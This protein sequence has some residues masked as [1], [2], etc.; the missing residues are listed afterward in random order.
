MHAPAR[1]FLISITVALVVIGTVG[2]TAVLDEPLVAVGSAVVIFAVTL[3]MIVGFERLGMIVLTLCFFM[4]PF[5]RAFP[6]VS[7]TAISAV[8]PLLVVAVGLLLP[9]IVRGKLDISPLYVVSGLAF[10][11]IGYA[12]AFSSETALATMNEITEWTFLAMVL[13]LAF[14]ALDLSRAEVSILAVAYIVGQMVSSAWAV[15]DGPN[16]VNNRYEGLAAHPNYFAD[17]AMM[18]ACLLLYLYH[19]PWARTLVMRVMW[20]GAFAVCGGAIYVSGSR[21][22]ALGMAAVLV[23]VPLIE[24]SG[25]YIFL[26]TLGTVTLLLFLQPIADRAGEGSTLARLTGQD[27]TGTRTTDFRLDEWHEAIDKIR[28]SPFLGNGLTLDILSFHNNYLSIA[29]GI[30]IFGVAAYLTTLWAMGRGLLSTS[31]QRRLLY[32]VVAFAVWGLTQPGF[33]DRSN[34]LPL[35]LGIAV[36]HC[37][38]TARASW[39]QEADEDADAAARAGIEESTTPLAPVADRSTP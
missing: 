12:A 31:A 14:V 19:E 15:V 2:A 1:S 25:V 29:A 28:E 22:A 13:A 18:A 34:W 24:R 35:L 38:R 39:A 26:A 16:P 3:L 5:F 30:G 6:I 21:G 33:K 9:R 10:M 27:G 11:I 4:A 17:G 20:W 23:L 36:F 8:D 32:P 37:Y 7:G